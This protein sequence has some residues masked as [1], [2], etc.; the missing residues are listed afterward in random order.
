MA[1]YSVRVMPVAKGIFKDHLTFFSKDGLPPGT[2]VETKIRGRA[3]PGIV[4]SST[5]V[6]EE[7]MDIRNADYALKKIDGENAKRVFLPAFMEAVRES[8]AWAGVHEGLV[9]ETLTSH[10][11]LSSLKRLTEAPAA[12]ERES[13]V[14][15]EV[16]VLQAEYAE[17]IRTYRNLAREA[18]AR[19][20]S[21]VI[22]APTVIEAETLTEELSRGVE[23]QVVLMSSE[24]TKTKLV[25]NWNRIAEETRPVLIIGTAFVLS[26]PRADVDTV[27]V[28]RESAKSYRTLRRPFLDVRRAAEAF[29]R[30]MGARCIL[31]DFP[32]RAETRYRTREHEAEELSRLQQRLSGSASIDILDSRPKDDMRGQKRM[33]TTLASET[34][35]AIGAEIKKGG[36][37][38]VF[39]ARKGLAPLTVC[40]D[41]GTPVSDPSSGM[42]MVLHKT[43]KGNVFISHKSGAVLP[44]ETA[45][46]VCG[47]WNLVTLGIGVDRVFEELSKEFHGAPLFL[48]T[49]ESAPNHKAAKKL[50]K[51]FYAEKG[52]VVV[53]TERMLPYLSKPAEIAAV[54]SIDSMLSLP[55]WRANEQALSILFYLRERAETRLIIET[56]EPAHEVMKAIASGNPSDF[57]RAEIEEREKYGYPPF[58]VFIGLTSLG[59]LADIAK[60]ETVI[61]ELFADADLVG[62]LPAEAIPRNMWRSRA[63][64]RLPAR[65]WPDPTL[66]Q[67]LKSLPPN[68]LVAVDPDEIV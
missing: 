53:G 4:L 28:E 19:G 63:A 21:A 37:A 14:V 17:R 40:N 9:A 58:S 13:G 42:P 18:F 1:M 49:K 24:L 64:L 15:S 5:D 65:A 60:A 67:K 44:A 22:L 34:K 27:I 56:R 59:S 3:V 51:E 43:P 8:A 48:F 11:I 68:V 25:A 57:Y 61:K 10:A 39:A 16:L 46:R 36:R 30:A 7:K 29:A 66:L 54:A 23:E 62:P 31:A 20:A 55:A 35:A 33:F 32:L 45:C 50:A 52:A 12:R 47:G 38:V 6:R 2:V 26:S 41:C